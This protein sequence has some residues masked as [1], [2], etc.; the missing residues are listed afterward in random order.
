MV[1]ELYEIYRAVLEEH[2]E[3]EQHDL[4][5]FL[6]EPGAEDRE[7]IAVYLHH[8]ARKENRAQHTQTTE[9]D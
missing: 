1:D 4:I 6:R 2:M 5:V 8:Y 3:I 7:P 9:A